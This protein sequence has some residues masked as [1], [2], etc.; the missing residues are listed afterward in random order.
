MAVEVGASLPELRVDG[1]AFSDHDLFCTME[2]LW[3]CH[4][5]RADDCKHR[6]PTL[7]VNMHR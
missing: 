3:R 4:G 2:V 6:V 1:R 7:V 5:D